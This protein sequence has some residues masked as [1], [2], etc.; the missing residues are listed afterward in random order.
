M[1]PLISVNISLPLPAALSLFRTWCHSLTVPFPLIDT[2]PFTASNLCKHLLYH[3]TKE[4]MYLVLF[5][6]KYTIL[7]HFTLPFDTLA[8]IVLLKALD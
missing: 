4:S 5:P 2:I 1:L 8:R 6:L 7:D 3:S